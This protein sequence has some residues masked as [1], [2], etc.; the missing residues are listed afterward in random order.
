MGEEINLKS[1]YKKMN[2]LNKLFWPKF[3][4]SIISFV[5]C[6]IISFFLSKKINTYGHFIISIIILLVEVIYI[7]IN[8]TS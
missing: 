5:S 1:F 8:I 3:I 4:L 2:F 7:V 6:I